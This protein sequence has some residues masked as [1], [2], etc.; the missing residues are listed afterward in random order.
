MDGLD[1]DEICILILIRGIK[2]NNFPFVFLQK[3]KNGPDIL[4]P[5]KCW[6]TS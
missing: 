3:K 5:K 1:V 6:T 2:R 4:I